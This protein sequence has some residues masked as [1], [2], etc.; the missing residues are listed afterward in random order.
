MNKWNKVARTARL[1]LAVAG[2]AASLVYTLVC[3]AQKL[4]G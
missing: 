3:L 1:W 4:G 2:G